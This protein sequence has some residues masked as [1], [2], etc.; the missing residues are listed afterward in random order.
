MSPNPFDRFIPR[1]EFCERARITQRTAELWAHAR[2]GPKVTIIAK[3]AYYA[4]E[5]VERWLK[6][7]QKPDTPPR[8]RRAA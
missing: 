5:D 3:R 8:K 1:A 2:K 4:V 6:A 7:C